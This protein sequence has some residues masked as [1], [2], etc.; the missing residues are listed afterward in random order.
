MDADD[1][2]NGLLNPSV[3]DAAQDPTLCHTHKDTK[4][5]NIMNLMFTLNW[6]LRGPNVPLLSVCHL[7][8]KSHDML[9]DSMTILC[10]SPCT[11]VN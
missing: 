1:G 10:P 9:H 4:N 11:L 5:V 7:H 3:A 6:Q 8:R 2:E